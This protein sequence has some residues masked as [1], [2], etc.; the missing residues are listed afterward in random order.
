MHAEALIAQGR[1]EEALERIETAERRLLEDDSDAQI[2]L[3]RARSQLA[4]KR[5]ALEEAESFAHRA[6]ERAARTDD[7][8]LRGGVLADLAALHEL[9]GRPAEAKAALE[10]ALALYEQKG[11]IVMAERVRER[12]AVGGAE[13]SAV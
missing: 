13:F 12:L 7:L 2:I 5:G 3:L 1:A 11:N 10:Q 9:S 4:A 8:S 6:N